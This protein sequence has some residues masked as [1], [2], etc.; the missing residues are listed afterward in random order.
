[1][2]I[3][4]ITP[5]FNKL[6]TTANRVKQNTNEIIIDIT[7]INQ[8]IDDFQTVVSIGSSV[9]DIKVGDLVCINPDRY[10]VKKYQQ[11]SASAEVEGYENT[12]IGYDIPRIALDDVEHLMITDSDVIYIVDEYEKIKKST[13]IDTSK[14]L[15]IP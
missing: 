9:R 2:N 6:V 8:V 5:M 15:I 7:K 11:K 12:I 13:I 10:A 3:K 4:K 14:K 1:M